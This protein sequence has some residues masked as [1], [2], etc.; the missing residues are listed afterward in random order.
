MF[1][2]YTLR[3]LNA[4]SYRRRMLTSHPSLEIHII[5]INIKSYFL[6]QEDSRDS[7]ERGIRYVYRSMSVRVQREQ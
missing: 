2:Y 4:Q 7:V 6:H 3:V 1:K 5:V